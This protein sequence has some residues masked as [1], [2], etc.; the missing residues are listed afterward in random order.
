MI[1]FLALL[2]CAGMAH[3]EEDV[4]AAVDARAGEFAAVAQAIWEH[5]ELGYLEERSS[6]LLQEHLAAAGFRIE[7]GVAGIPTA[8]VAE[9]GQGEPVVALLAEFDAL[10]GLSQQAVA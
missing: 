5:A 9:Y 10:P 7:R 4:V 2:L 8:F 3:G 6:A 1:G